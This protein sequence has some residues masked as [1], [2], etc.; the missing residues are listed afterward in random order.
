VMTYTTAD[1]VVYTTAGIP[2]AAGGNRRV[3]WREIF[4]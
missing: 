2:I 3:G 4:R 1:G